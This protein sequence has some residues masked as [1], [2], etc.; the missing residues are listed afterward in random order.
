[1]YTDSTLKP[2]QDN[3]QY[4]AADG[5]QYPWNYSKDE[6]PGLFKVT[7]TPRPS[8][9]QLVVLGY[10]IDNEHKQFWH[11]RAMTPEE[12]L[13]YTQSLLAALAAHRYAVQTGGTIVADNKFD[14]DPESC[15][16][17][18]AA[19]VIASANPD[20]SCNWKMADGTFVSLNSQQIVG[21][22]LG[23][24]GFV[25]KCF[26]SEGAVAARI[27]QYST[28]EMVVAAFDNEMKNT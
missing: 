5:T 25:Q 14:T 9:P 7:E 19:F 27:A 20:Y 26:D 6:I 3:D 22:G 28:I 2:I 12:Q 23:V 13:A 8:D 1:M 15:S 16:A 10:I 18:T 24:L 11:T 17:L 21:A 4:I